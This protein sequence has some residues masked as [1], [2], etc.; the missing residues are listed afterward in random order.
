ENE[1]LYEAAREQ[2]QIHVQLNQAL[3]EAL[4]AGSREAAERVRA[5][6]ETSRQQEELHS[7][8]IQ[9]PV[10]I[11]VFAGNDLVY[12]L[13]NPA[14]VEILGRDPVGMPLSTAVPEVAGQGYDELLRG[15]MRTGEPVV[16]REA[17]V[18]LERDGAVQELFFNFVISAI[19]ND[20]APTSRVIL[21]ASDVTEQVRARQRAEALT[22][23]LAAEKKRLEAVLAQVRK[24]G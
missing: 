4:D 23:Q 10:A 20:P 5:E 2:T 8:W 21:V 15:V 6:G 14:Y 3:R 1:R 7:M 24:L 11:C 18:R 19:R 12:E 9:A 16:Q 13:A 22:V 17:P